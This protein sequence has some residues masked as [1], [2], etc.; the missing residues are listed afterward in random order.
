MGN[1]PKNKKPKM[2]MMSCLNCGYKW[3]PRI[4]QPKSCPLCKAYFEK[5]LRRKTR[6]I[7]Q[8]RPVLGRPLGLV[9]VGK[10]S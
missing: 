3:Q 7:I 2:K 5:R 6:A 4:A 9:G 8:S 10:S 1:L